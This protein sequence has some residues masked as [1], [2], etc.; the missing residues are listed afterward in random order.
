MGKFR[1]LHPSTMSTPKLTSLERRTLAAAI[2]G[3][4]Q[5]RCVPSSLLRRPPRG[6]GF[7]PETMEV[8]VEAFGVRRGEQHR[9]F[10]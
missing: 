1:L 2:R 10:E 5:N 9:L 6:K 4:A 8:I 7:D 3:P